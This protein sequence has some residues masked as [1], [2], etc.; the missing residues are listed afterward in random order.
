MSDFSFHH[1]S[2]N[3]SN[4]IKSQDFYLSLGFEVCYNY[5]SLDGS[6]K[7]VHLLKGNFILELFYYLVAPA[8]K[9]VSSEIAH[10]DFVGIEHFSLQ[11]DDIERAHKQL[12]KNII[13]DKGIQ[14]GRT[15]IR[16]FFINDPDGNRIEIVEDKRDLTTQKSK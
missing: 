15:G 11:T 12:Y 13:Q 9:T 10:N 5:C 16:F 6:V 4:L 14:L 7:I 2:I 8:C 1:V 3:V